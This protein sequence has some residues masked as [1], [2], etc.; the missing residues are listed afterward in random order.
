[1]CLVFPITDSTQRDL[2]GGLFYLC[3]EGTS[4]A[5]VYGDRNKYSRYIDNY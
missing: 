1:M 5:T 4:L 2:A 3:Y